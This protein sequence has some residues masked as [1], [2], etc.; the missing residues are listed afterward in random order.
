MLYSKK[1]GKKKISIIIIIIT[2]VTIIM[3]IIITKKYSIHKTWLILGT[4]SIKEKKKKRHPMF[5]YTHFQIGKATLI[6]SYH[7]I[8]Y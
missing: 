1:K 4:F 3:I 2:I 6:W 7:F 8:K 5:N